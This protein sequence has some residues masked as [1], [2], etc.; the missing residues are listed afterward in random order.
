MWQLKI[1]LQYYSVI[2]RR[3]IPGLFRTK[4][5]FLKPKWGSLREHALSIV[6]LKHNLPAVPAVAGQQ[7]AHA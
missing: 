3:T 7:L 2:K 5:G 6:P 4:A 1:W